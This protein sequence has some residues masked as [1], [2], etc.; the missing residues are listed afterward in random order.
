MSYVNLSHSTVKIRKD[1]KCTSCLRGFPQGTLMEHWAGVGNGGFMHYY[2]CPTCQQ[3]LDMLDE[4]VYYEGEVAN[5]LEEG[6]TPEEMLEKMKE[7]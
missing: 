2:A 5:L 3:I 4:T 1:R 7:K 6:Q